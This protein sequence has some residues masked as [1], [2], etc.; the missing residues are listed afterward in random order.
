MIQWVTATESYAGLADYRDIVQRPMNFELVLSNV[1]D[2]KYTTAEA[3]LADVDLIAAN[4]I[5]YNPD[6][7]ADRVEL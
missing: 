7:G 1:N 6:H 5:Q 3:F 2:G 4:A